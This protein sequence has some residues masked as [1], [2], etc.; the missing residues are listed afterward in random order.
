[1]AVKFNV[2]KALDLYKEKGGKTA[3]PDSLQ[4]VLNFIQD[5]NNF[6]HVQEVAWLLATAKVESDYSLTR[7]ESDYLCGKWGNKYGDNPCQKALNYYRSTDGKKDY[8]SLG[9]DKNGLPYYGRG[10]IQLTGKENYK[11]FGDTLG[12]NLIDDANKAREPK[13]SYKIASAYFSK[14]KAGY[15][16]T[17]NGYVMAGDFP[18]ARKIVKGSSKKWEE[19]KKVYDF[20]L[21]VLNKSDL[22]RKKKVKV[23]LTEKQ[24]KTRRTVGYAVLGLS[25]AG[26]GFA[27]WKITRK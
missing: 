8:F 1:M 21:D 15:S 4:Q 2:Q 6:N 5:D 11:H 14:P 23:P 20:W 19:A 3:F 22:G 13:I 27:I 7:W 18:M 16:K 25:L 26:L 10:L 17:V 9:L 24:K 12:I